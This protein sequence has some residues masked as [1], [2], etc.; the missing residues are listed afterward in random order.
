MARLPGLLC[1]GSAEL[2]SPCSL[3]SF[4]LPWPPTGLIREAGPSAAS[5]RSSGSRR[6]A[7]RKKQSV[8]RVEGGRCE[9][10][11]VGFFLLGK[12][13]LYGYIFAGRILLD[14]DGKVKHFATG[15]VVGKYEAQQG[16]GVNTGGLGAVLGV[17]YQAACQDVLHFVA[18]A[19]ASYQTSIGVPVEGSAEGGA[20]AVEEAAEG[21]GSAGAGLYGT[22]NLRRRQQHQQRRRRRCVCGRGG[23]EQRRPSGTAATASTTDPA[24]ARSPSLTAPQHHPGGDC[25]QGTSN[26]CGGARGPRSSD[27][28]SEGGSGEYR[29][30]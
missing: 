2:V 3:P 27:M 1:L 18:D 17:S 5:T 19:I 24:P 16:K 11:V 20:A 30:S 26:T 4:A 8:G 12:G 22:A 28:V 10:V 6:A 13:Q 29:G 15:L 14:A 23:G 25:E 9:Q 7:S 21:A